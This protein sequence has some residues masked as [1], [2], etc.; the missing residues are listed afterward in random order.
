[1]YFAKWLNTIIGK[2]SEFKKYFKWSDRDLNRWCFGK[3]TPSGG[4]QAALLR[5]ISLHTGIKLETILMQAHFE[6]LKDYNQ[7]HGKSKDNS[8]T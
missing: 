4:K 7:E 2:K 6:H 5:D 1:M 8:V 3:N